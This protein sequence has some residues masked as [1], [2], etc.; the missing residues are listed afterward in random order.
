MSEECKHEFVDRVIRM[1]GWY[2]ATKLVIYC[3]RCGHVSVERFIG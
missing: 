3:K 2:Q 1:G